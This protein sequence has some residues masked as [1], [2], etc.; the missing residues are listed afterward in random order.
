MFPGS[1]LGLVMVRT[2]KLAGQA[3]DLVCIFY[4]SSVPCLIREHG[5]SFKRD[6][7]EY[8]FVAQCYLDGWMYGQNELALGGANFRMT[9]SAL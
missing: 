5:M 9:C 7:R 2:G 3:G 4:G 1:W 8:K 6:Q